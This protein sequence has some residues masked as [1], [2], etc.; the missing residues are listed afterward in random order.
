MAKIHYYLVNESKK[1]FCYFNARISI[2]EELK[3]I[4]DTWASWT[5]TDTIK[6]HGD[7]ESKGPD[8]WEHLTVN[9]EYRDLDYDQQASI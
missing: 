3:R 7:D 6:L 1:E 5:P 8:L 9:L 4:M 2:H